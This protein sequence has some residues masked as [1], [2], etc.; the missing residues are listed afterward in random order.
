[1][2]GR[3]RLAATLE[4]RQP[5]RVCVDFGA[6]WV[7]GM[8]ASIVDKLRKAVLGDPDWRV[9]VI[10]PYQMLGEIDDE[11]REALGIDVVGVL[12]RKSLF[13]TGHDR[14]EA[15]HAVRRHRGA[16]AARTSTRPSTR[17][18]AIC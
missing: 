3:E 14:L 17:P 7:T 15:V 8:H 6:T 4:H 5:D 16:R 13:G 10:E 18:P 9:K 1:M 12:T 11:L 2:T